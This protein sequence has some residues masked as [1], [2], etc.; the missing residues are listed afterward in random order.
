MRRAPGVVALTAL[1][2]VLAG[3]SDSSEP[4]TEESPSAD[5][6]AS[7]TESPTDEASAEQTEKPPE[8]SESGVPADVEED[9][10]ARL[11]AADGLLGTAPDADPPVLGLE[12]FNAG[13]PPEQLEAL[14]ERGFVAGAYE[15]LK[16][17][18]TVDAVRVAI[19]FETAEGAAADV[20]AGADDL[21]GEGEVKRFDV[22]G[23]PGGEGFDVYGQQ[24]LVGRNVA[25]SVDEFE[26][27]VGVATQQPPTKPQVTREEISAVAQDWYDAVRALD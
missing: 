25:F 8:T 2:V 4:E 24:G 26:L 12:E 6:S 17:P 16:A 14:E 20:K 10:L 7:A 1:V 21:P 9:V 22:P 5:A 3:C 11:A 18:K 23:V 27:I 13:A 15:Q 19:A